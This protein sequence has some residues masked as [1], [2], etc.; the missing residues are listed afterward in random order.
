MKK[1]QISLMPYEWKYIS[2]VL[3]K[4]AME[5][6]M[7]TNAEVGRREL[8]RLRKIVARAAG[9]ETATSQQLGTTAD[10]AG[11]DASASPANGKAV[12]NTVSA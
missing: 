5:M 12:G 1:K 4:C 10:Q 11:K 3:D 2:M 9:E 7:Y 8:H 6:T